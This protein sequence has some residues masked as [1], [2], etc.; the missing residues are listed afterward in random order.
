MAIP[1][2][3][4]V[5]KLAELAIS[6]LSRQPFGAPNEI[7]CFDLEGHFDC[8]LNFSRRGGGSG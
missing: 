7:L 1:R 6:T 2:Q 3:G 8:E 5:V 4:K